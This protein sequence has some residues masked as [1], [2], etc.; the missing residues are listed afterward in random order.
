MYPCKKMAMIVEYA[1]RIA[2]R[3]SLNF[4][5][6]DLN[7]AGARERMTQELLEGRINPDW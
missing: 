1:E 3:S 5:Q 4:I 6:K 7:L 2:R